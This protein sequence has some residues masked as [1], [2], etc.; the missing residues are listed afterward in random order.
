M[1]PSCYNVIC[2][3][4]NGLIVWNSRSGGVLG[5][6]K[7]Y[8]E[9]FRKIL[10]GDYSGSD[11]L[12]EQ[13]V[14]GEMLVED[15]RDEYGET[16]VKSHLARYSNDV[17]ALTIAPT[18]AC[19]F[20]CPYCY[21]KGQKQTTMSSVTANRLV[22]FVHDNF[23]NIRSFDVTWYG[24]EP[25]LC[26]ETIKDLTDKLKLAV[27]SW[28]SFGASIVTNGYYLTRDVA[29]VLAS[30][31]VKMAQVTLD[32]SKRDHDARRIPAD[33]SPTYEMI[34]NNIA[35]C[36]DVIN[37]VIRANV[38]KTNIRDA[39]EL[40]NNLEHRDLKNKVGFYLAPVDN[41]NKTCASDSQ[42]FGMREYSQEEI[43]FYK[44][45]INRGFKVKLFGGTGQAICGAVSRNVYVVGPDGALYKCWDEIG[46]TERAVGTVRD[47]IELNENLARWLG[48]EPDDEECARCSVFPICMGGCPH[49][50]LEGAGKVCSSLRFNASEKMELTKM[51]HGMDREK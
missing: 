12:L 44:E 48:Y 19:N 32:G 39:D 38:D 47:S 25:L 11:D 33:G 41:I 43:G 7:V 18:L 30:C 42:C 34:L 16:L 51:L 45:A 8:S 14:H 9:K 46:K 40:L 37:I 24:G 15:G 28:C 1:K 22:A 21:E 35:E 5:L 17:L 49:H 29:Q 20:R 23:P 36:A 10:D 4:N 26:L 2:E 31:E 6:D 27:P 50:V 13:L 3:N